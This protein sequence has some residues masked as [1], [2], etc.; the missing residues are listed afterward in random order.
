[1]Q[2]NTNTTIKKITMELKSTDYAIA[3][4]TKP[5]IIGQTMRAG[6]C[7]GQHNIINLGLVSSCICI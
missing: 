1:M 6:F 7:V 4:F 5:L 2:K 3:I